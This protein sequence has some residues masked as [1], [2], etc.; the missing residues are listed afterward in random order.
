MSEIELSVALEMSRRPSLRIPRQRLS[1][2]KRRW[3]G[4][5]GQ[6]RSKRVESG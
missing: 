5:E 3:I 2:S 4:V 6:M 1:W